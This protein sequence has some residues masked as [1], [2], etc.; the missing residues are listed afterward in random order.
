[1]LLGK[2]KVIPVFA[3]IILIVGTASAIYVHSTQINKDTITI[4]GEEYTIDQLFKISEKRTIQ[5]DTN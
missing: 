4:Q 3:M 1:M 5:T 2:E